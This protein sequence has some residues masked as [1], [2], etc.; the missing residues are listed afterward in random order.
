M[1]LVQQHIKLVFKIDQIGGWPGRITSPSSVAFLPDGNLV[2]SECEN[3]LQVFDSAG[4]S[5]RIMGWGKMKPQTVVINREG[6]LVLTDKKDQCV[7]V[8]DMNGDAVS[9]WGTGLFASPSGIAVSSNGNVIVTDLETNNVSIHSPDGGVISQFGS[10]GS[11]DYQFNHPTHVTVDQQDNIIVSD[12][13]NS[14]I[15]VYNKNG[16]FVQKFS[17]L[18]G[19]QGLLRRPHGV[20]ADNIGNILIADHDNHRISLFSSEGKFLHHLMTKQDGIRYPTAICFDR[21]YKHIAVVES[22]VG[23]MSK[24]PHH[25]VKV[26]QLS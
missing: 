17:L 1:S 6:Q 9:T 23:F 11:G 5:I 25:A 15:K 4:H 26:Y 10:W 20:A 3:R 2:I 21:N 7:K 24:D 14:L 8:F 18:S 13:G 16:A 12:A 19:K 22:H